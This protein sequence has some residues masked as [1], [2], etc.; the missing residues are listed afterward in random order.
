MRITK[1]RRLTRVCF[2][3]LLLD[4]GN[5]RWPAQEESLDGSR[6]RTRRRRSSSEGLRYSRHPMR[7]LPRN[8]LGVGTQENWGHRWFMP[9]YNPKPSP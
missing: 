9:I 4:R 5:E 3:V 8:A 6:R 7:H 1:E 2:V